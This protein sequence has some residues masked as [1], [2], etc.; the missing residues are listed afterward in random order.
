MCM[1]K[2]KD[3]DKLSHKQYEILNKQKKDCALTE[4]WLRDNGLNKSHFNTADIKLIQA[5]QIA[6]TLLTQHKNLLTQDQ[7]NLLH[8]FQRKTASKKQFIKLKTNHAYPILN[9]GTKINRKLYK[10]YRQLQ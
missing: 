4:D 10:K 8:N 3:K 9:I 2:T 7:I 6:H 5:Q 1:N